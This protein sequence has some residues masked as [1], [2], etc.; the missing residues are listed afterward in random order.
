M[1][2]T[3]TFSEREYTQLCRHLFTDDS[4][5][6]A[7]IVFCKK[8]ITVAETRLLVK[9]IRP[10]QSNEVLEQS[11]L[12]IRVPVL[13]YSHA[14]QKA[15]KEE[16]CFFWVH[17]HPGGYL[18]YSEE[19]DREE[20]ELFR[21]ANI[22]VPGQVH[23][24]LL[25]NSP[26]GITGRVW[27]QN[28][29]RDVYSLPLDM[30]RIIGPQYKFF[31]PT[32][33]SDLDLSAFDRNVRAFG[34]DMQHLLKSLHVGVVGA[35]GTGSPMIEQLSRL[36]I[37]TISIY[38]DDTLS[39]TNL[40]RIHGA[41][42]NQIGQFKVDIMGNMI[43]GIGLRT[44][45]LHYNAR[46]TDIEIA[47]T[48]RD[49][50][51]I[52]GCT[53]DQ[54]GRSI[55]SDISLRYYI[56]LFDMG[57]RIDSQNEVLNDILGRLTIVQPGSACLFCLG[58]VNPHQMMMESKTKEERDNL[59]REGYAAELAEADPAVIAYTTAIASLATAELINK[60]TGLS[61]ESDRTGLIYDFGNHQV[62]LSSTSRKKTCKCGQ[63]DVLG[64]G[65]M[66][67]FLDLVWP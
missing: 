8:S 10:I 11:P 38:D 20:P 43:E 29:V 61:R 35:S 52:F 13:V 47:K 49:C 65:D 9:E 1:R 3:L 24:S 34:K 44:N 21:P 25:L 19:D 16:Y 58:I 22:R 53:D 26:D 33:R 66:P 7:A 14:F 32:G 12:N 55:L 36:G 46:I 48:L 27:L 2:Y 4:V 67:M 15:A 54:L 51:I 60:L 28:E 40:T 23:G 50:D 63:V 59:V 57:V 31:F 62:H 64:S 18:E 17:S 30:I 56:P 37:G 6:Q 45:V 5:E 39:E 41:A 42:R